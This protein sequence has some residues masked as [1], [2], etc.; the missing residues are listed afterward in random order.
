MLSICPRGG[1]RAV[2]CATVRIADLPLVGFRIHVQCNKLD[3]VSHTNAMWMQLDL[4]LTRLALNARLILRGWTYVQVLDATAV[5][6]ASSGYSAALD[7]VYVS[8]KL[9]Q[10]AGEVGPRVVVSNVV[11]GGRCITTESICNEDSCVPS[12]DKPQSRI[13]LKGGCM[14]WLVSPNIFVTAEHCSD[15]ML[16]SRMSFTFSP[17]RSPVNP[18]DQYAVE[19]LTFRKDHQVGYNNPDWDVGRLLPNTETGM[20]PGVAQG[21]WY[22]IGTVARSE[23]GNVHITGYSTNNSLQNLMQQTHTG[24]MTFVFP[25]DVHYDADLMVSSRMLSFVLANAKI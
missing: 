15:P 19:L 4:N 1:P 12:F 8:V 21:G 23:G 24:K 13:V 16:S 22:D 10:L 9:K 20:L 7:R 2:D 18:K 5:T 6:H 14:G 17:T 11:M 25:N 3:L